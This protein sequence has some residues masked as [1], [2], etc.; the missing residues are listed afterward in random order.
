MPGP[1]IICI[2]LHCIA[3]HCYIYDIYARN[4]ISTYVDKAVAQ[5]AVVRLPDGSEELPE[6]V[7]LHDEFMYTLI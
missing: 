5:R 1:L 2:A 4:N 7:A 6:E 3:L